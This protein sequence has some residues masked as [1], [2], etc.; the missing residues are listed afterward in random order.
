MRPPRVAAGAR[1]V[2]LPRAQAHRTRME[3]RA[4]V[5]RAL[6]F[7]AEAKAQLERA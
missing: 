6:A 7:E 1:P 5:Q 3:A 2:G 4:S